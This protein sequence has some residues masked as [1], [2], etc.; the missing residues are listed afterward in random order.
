MNYCYWLSFSGKIR[1]ILH[2]SYHSV[3]RNQQIRMLLQSIPSVLHPPV[4]SSLPLLLFP[5]MELLQQTRLH[6]V[7]PFL[8]VSC[9]KK[10]KMYQSYAN[11]FQENIKRSIRR[12][13]N[14]ECFAFNEFNISGWKWDHHEWL[15]WRW[16]DGMRLKGHRRWRHLIP[17]ISSSSSTKSRCKIISP[18][19]LKEF[20]SNTTF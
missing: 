16:R 6:S 15:P 5:S 4:L 13:R 2:T 19:R 10:P 3:H 7:C 20:L 14:E 12:D 1:I 18:I 11:T 9:E 8:W 17:S